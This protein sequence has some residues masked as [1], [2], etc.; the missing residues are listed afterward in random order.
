MAE[1]TSPHTRFHSLQIANKGESLS[2]TQDGIRLPAMGRCKEI[3]AYLF[4]EPKDGIGA[5]RRALRRKGSVLDANLEEVRKLDQ[6]ISRDDRGRMEQYLTSVRETEIRTERAD[7]WLDIPRPEIAEADR[8]RTNRD[9][10]QTQAGEYFRTIY[11]LMVLAFQTDATR[12]ATFSR[13]NE[14]Q[15]LPIPELGIPQ[16][17][18]ELSHHNGDPNHMENLTLSDTFSFEQYAYFISRLAGDQRS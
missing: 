16:S 15:G 12:V 10:P 7:A 13:G 9:V 8:K 5:Q 17:R 3:F 14:G 4:E 11:D 6:K 18:H 2:W 1:I